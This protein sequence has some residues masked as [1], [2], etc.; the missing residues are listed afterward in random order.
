MTQTQQS[1]AEVLATVA[2]AWRGTRGPVP[3]E[4]YAR[5]AGPISPAP[6]SLKMY[7]ASPALVDRAAQIRRCWP[8]L[9]IY[10]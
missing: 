8:R 3:I 1:A 10:Y 6:V 5:N 4:L 7:V 9:C 2:S